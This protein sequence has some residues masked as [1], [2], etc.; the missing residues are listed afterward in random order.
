MEYV[1]PRA[2][3][4]ASSERALRYAAVRRREVDVGVELVRVEREIGSVTMR[5]GG[6]GRRRVEGIIVVVVGR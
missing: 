2:G 4:G 3:P 5:R 1:L 6:R